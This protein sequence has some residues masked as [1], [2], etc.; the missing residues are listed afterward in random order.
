MVVAHRVAGGADPALTVA[1]DRVG[2]GVVQ[3][4]GN[5]DFLEGPVDRHERI[6]LRVRPDPHEPVTHEGAAIIADRVDVAAAPFAGV[7]GGDDVV[8]GRVP[9]CVELVVGG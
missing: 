7:R 5:F 8:G 9:D 3:A 6:H 2:D 1:R 4:V